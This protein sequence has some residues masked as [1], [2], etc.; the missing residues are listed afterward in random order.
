M[1]STGPASR[2]YQLESGGAGPYAARRVSE[3]LRHRQGSR[4]YMTICISRC[5][6]IIRAASRLLTST[7]GPY[8]FNLIT[9]H[10]LA[11][12]CSTYLFIYSFYPVLDS[13]CFIQAHRYGHIRPVCEYIR[14]FRNMAKVRIASQDGRR[15]MS[16]GTPSST[17]RITGLCQCDISFGGRTYTLDA[18]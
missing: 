11:R 13:A 12:L 14:V 1:L 16:R 15:C 17:P 2:R 6:Y 8:T 7:M 10:F 9:L 3:R 4:V 5:M 18:T